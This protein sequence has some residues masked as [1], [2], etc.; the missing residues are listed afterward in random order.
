MDS[1]EDIE[2]AAK[3]LAEDNGWTNVSKASTIFGNG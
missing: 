2:K 3:K 1:E